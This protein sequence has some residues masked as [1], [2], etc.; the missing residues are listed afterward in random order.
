MNGAA[1]NRINTLY[2][3]TYNGQ[4]ITSNIGS[5]QEFGRNKNG[6]LSE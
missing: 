6:N 2:I 1:Y 4:F 3:D 5:I